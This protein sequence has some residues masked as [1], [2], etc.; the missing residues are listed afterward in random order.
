MT[1]EK[2]YIFDTTLRD[3][4]QTEGVDFSIEDK[5]KIAKA[6]SEIGIDYVEGGWPGANPVDTKFF[7]NPPSMNKT[8]FTAFG[9]TKKTGR[10]ADNDP[11]LASL[12]NA[13]TPAV[14]VVGK[15]WDFHVKVALGIKN[16]ENLENIRETA[17]H[18]VKNNKNFYL[19]QNIFLMDIK[20]IQIMQ[21]IV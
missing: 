1:K 5:N 2:I 20:L 21:L 4:A 12:I 7:S 15:S 10:S 16:E 19:M 17:K 14:C 11:G 3:G 13:N 8:L 9:M 18:F 6:L